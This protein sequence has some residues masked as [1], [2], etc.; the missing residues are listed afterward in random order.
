MTKR[1]FPLDLFRSLTII[2]MIIVNNPGNRQYVYAPLK[3]ATYD[4][5]TLAD[6][7]FPCFIFMMGLAIA[8]SIDKANTLPHKKI[9]IRAISLFAIGL[10][11]NIIPFHLNQLSLIFNPDKWRIFGVLQRLAII[12]LSSCYLSHG[13]KNSFIITFS[14]SLLVLYACLLLFVPVPFNNTTTLTGN[15]NHG[16]TITA[17]IDYLLINSNHLYFKHTPYP[18]DPEGLLSTLPG[19]SSCLTGIVLGR[20]LRANSAKNQNFQIIITGCGLLLIM[21]SIMLSL[22][23]PLNKTIWSPS[24]STLSTGF[25]LCLLS[26]CIYLDSFD[27]ND[28]W[29]KKFYFYGQHSLNAYVGSIILSKLSYLLGINLLVYKIIVLVITDPYMASL[30]YACLFLLFCLIILELWATKH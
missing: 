14:L 13:I 4:G 11:L 6:L 29:L 25:S 12:Y 15:L 28:F 26:V 19:I 5:C 2:L 18:Y 8:F 16:Q 23:Y 7:I 10:C 30:I 1:F 22:I 20:Y 9:I 21:L 27:I 24:F 3:H 17:Y